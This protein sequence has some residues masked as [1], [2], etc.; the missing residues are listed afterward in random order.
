MDESKFWDICFNESLDDLTIKEVKQANRMFQDKMKIIYKV[1]KEF[2]SSLN[3]MSSKFNTMKC[4]KSNYAG[5]VYDECDIGLVSICE[6]IMLH[7]QEFFDLFMKE[8]FSSDLLDIFDEGYNGEYVKGPERI[9]LYMEY[10]SVNHCLNGWA[11]KE[12]ESIWNKMLNEY[13]QNYVNMCKYE[14]HDELAKI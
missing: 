4:Q 3:G 6:S 12:R 7:G 11:F 5:L 10:R 14:L 2:V 8:P 9:L 1:A 13:F